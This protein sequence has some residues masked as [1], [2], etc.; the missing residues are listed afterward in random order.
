MLQASTFSSCS[1]LADVRLLN[2]LWTARPTASLPSASNVT[3]HLATTTDATGSS[4]QA[5]GA[6]SSSIPLVLLAQT[7]EMLGLASASDA[8]HPS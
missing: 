3:S 7:T 5:V 1:D 6:A 4:T 2:Y 8:L